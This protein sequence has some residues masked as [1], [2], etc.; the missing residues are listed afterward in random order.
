MHSNRKIPSTKQ[1][2]EEKRLYNQRLIEFVRDHPIL[3]DCKLEDYKN[4]HKKANVWKEFGLQN[5]PVQDDITVKYNWNALRSN[6][7]RAKS[8]FL[9]ELA[10]QTNLSRLGSI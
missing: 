1:N 9:L 7:K 6:Y 4:N 10:R 2:D 8:N 3:W 5:F